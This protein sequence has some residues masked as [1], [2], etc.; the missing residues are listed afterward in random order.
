MAY[1]I[2]HCNISM[3]ADDHHLYVSRKI[4]QEVEAA[5]NSDIE[6]TTTWYKSN[7]LSANKQKYQAMVI[8]ENHTI[9]KHEA[10]QVKAHG[11]V[12]D[13]TDKLKLLG[14]TI[15]NK[16]I[17]S[18]HIRTVCIKSSQKI[19]VIFRLRNLIPTATKPRL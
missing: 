9:D 10:I 5:L 11:D 6:K 19:G 15:D 14:V 17:L 1:G 16:M 18:E 13:Q 2:E 12:I 3:Y 7:F 8:H 4:S